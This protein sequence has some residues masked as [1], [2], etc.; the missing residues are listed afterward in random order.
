MAIDE[1]AKERLRTL[2]VEVLLCYRAA[3]LK[4]G[5]SPLKHWD[6]LQDRMRSAARRSQTP[7]EWA[8]ALSRGLQ[9][10]SLNVDGKRGDVLQ[11]LIDL[12][13]K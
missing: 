12:L 1:Q 4:A 9:L 2:T 7:E 10:P 11:T 6:Q 13:A 3:Y 8:T 5:A